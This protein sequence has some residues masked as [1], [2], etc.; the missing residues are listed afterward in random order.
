MQHLYKRLQPKSRQ[1]KKQKTKKI[2]RLWCAYLRDTKQNK[3]KTQTKQL[4]LYNTFIN[5]KPNNKN[6]NIITKT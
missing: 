6:I 3:R 1:Q 5:C 2:G 4:T